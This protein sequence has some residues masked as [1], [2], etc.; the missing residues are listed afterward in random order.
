MLYICVYIYTLYKYVYIYNIYIYMYVYIHTYMYIYTNIYIYTHIYIYYIYIYIYISQS[1]S[2]TYHILKFHQLAKEAFKKYF[3]WC[4]YKEIRSEIETWSTGR[5]V[6]T[7]L[8]RN[9]FMEK[10]YRKYTPK[11]SVIL[12]FEACVCYFLINFYF[13][14]KR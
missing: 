11:T 2:I 6:V 8:V 1:L 14:P 7:C 9:N 10:V 13:L 12:L 3:G 5:V 4:L